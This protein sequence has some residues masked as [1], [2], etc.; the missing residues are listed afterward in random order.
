MA[1]YALPAGSARLYACMRIHMP[2]CLGIHVQACTDQYVI[3][4]FH[5]LSVTLYVHCLSSYTLKYCN[6]LW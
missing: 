4:L 2:T 1:R 5:S 6:N 3:Q